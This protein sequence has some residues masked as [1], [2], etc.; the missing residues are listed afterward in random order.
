[1]AV[2]AAPKPATAPPRRHLVGF[3]RRRGRWVAGRIR[4]AARRGGAP[5]AG[6]TTAEYA[7]GTVA[8]CALAAVLF[9]VVTS[10]TVLAALTGVLERALGAA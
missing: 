5:D 9:K 10:D 7:V 2:V 3:C 1:M 8:A 4:R 6:M